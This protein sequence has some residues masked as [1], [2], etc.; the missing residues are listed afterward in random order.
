MKLIRI[1]RLLH[2]VRKY[3]AAQYF[4]PNYADNDDVD[5]A[6]CKWWWWWC[7]WCNDDDDDDDEYDG[8]EGMLENG[9][10]KSHLFDHQDVDA[11]ELHKVAMSVLRW[12]WTS[13][14]TLG[15]NKITI[16]T[17]FEYLNSD[18]WTTRV[19]FR[20]KRD[21]GRDD[22]EPIWNE[23]EQK[24]CTEEKVNT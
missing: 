21:G 13:K 8:Y 18:N 24:A 4:P 15:N 12:T 11:V 9:M 19:S 23:K 5:M 20:G 6:G 2:L 14:A 7:L 1:G 3:L 16:V 10:F 17:T 22:F